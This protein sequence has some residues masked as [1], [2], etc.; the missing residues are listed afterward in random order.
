M[1][2]CMSAGYGPQQRISTFTIEPSHTDD[3]MPPISLECTL[4]CRNVIQND[5]VCEVR[6]PYRITHTC[7]IYNVYTAKHMCTCNHTRLISRHP[8]TCRN[9][10]LVVGG[11]ALLRLSWNLLHWS[12]SRDECHKTG[13]EGGDGS[14]TS[15]AGS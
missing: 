7:I 10:F 9:F 4:Q 14:G 3:V 5:S 2:T 12:Q 1:Y 8:R 11:V 15:R 13:D 6:N